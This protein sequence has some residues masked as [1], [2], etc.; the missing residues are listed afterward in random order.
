MLDATHGP[1]ETTPYFAAPIEGTFMAATERDPR[2]LRIA[3]HSEPALP[4]TVH[5][6]C[7]AAVQDAA[8]LCAELGHYVDAISPKHD[9]LALGRAFLM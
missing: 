9:A 2:P 3:F 1:D 5:P 7:M 8:Q 6:D 4:A